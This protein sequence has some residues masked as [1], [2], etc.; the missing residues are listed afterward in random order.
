MVHQLPSQTCSP[1]S[2]C[3]VPCGSDSVTLSFLSHFWAA[4]WIAFLIVHVRTMHFAWRL[5][6]DVVILAEETANVLNAS[7]DSMF[8][9]CTSCCTLRLWYCHILYDLK[10]HHLMRIT[11]EDTTTTMWSCWL[12][13]LYLAMYA[14]QY[15]ITPPSRDNQSVQWDSKSRT[16]NNAVGVKK[17]LFSHWFRT[18]IWNVFILVFFSTL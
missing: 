2:A 8:L 15:Y 7:F 9:L 6:L 16:P 10:N 17:L 5:W 14:E 18:V 3:Y 13:G 12:G 1:N 4:T 11:Q